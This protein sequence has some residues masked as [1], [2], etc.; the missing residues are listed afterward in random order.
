MKQLLEQ[1]R[2][3]DESLNFL[4]RCRHRNETTGV[5]FGEVKESVAKSFSRTLTEESFR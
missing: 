4:K 3:I 5:S 2:F 1:A